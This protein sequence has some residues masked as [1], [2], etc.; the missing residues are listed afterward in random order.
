MGIIFF[1]TPEFAVPSLKALIESGELRLVITQSQKF[2]RDGSPIPIPVKEL[3]S[4][5]R[6][7]VLQPERIRDPEFINIIKKYNPEFIIVVAYGKILPPEI[8]SIPERFPIN[9][10]A[11]LLPKYRGA[12]PVQWAIINGER[13]TGVTTMVMDEGLDTGKILLQE[14]TEIGE[15][16]DS[17]SLS[18]RLSELGAQLLLKTIDGIRKGKIIPRPQEGEPSYAPTLKKED[19]LIDWNRPAREIYNLIRGTQPWP[20]A[21][22]FLEGER[23]IITR[24][25]VID[26]RGEPGRIE[27]TEKGFIIGTGNGLLKILELKPEGKKVMDGASF[28]RGRRLKRGIILGR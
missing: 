16:E 20:C 11:S 15:D 25:S 3:A 6:I 22:T 21:Y 5:S 24:A 26:G 23:L 9:V 27:D 1:G 2:R 8:L 17:L 14:S 19:G 18:K 10:H 4:K 13:I 28:L 12:A 7:P